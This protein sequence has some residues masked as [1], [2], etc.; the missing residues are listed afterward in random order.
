MIAFSATRIVTNQHD[1]IMADLWAKPDG[2]SGLEKSK[3][4]KNNLEQP[5]NQTSKTDND[6]LSYFAVIPRWR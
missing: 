6:V 4:T 2:E 5:P 3:Q 1:N